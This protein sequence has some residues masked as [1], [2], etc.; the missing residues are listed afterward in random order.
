MNNNDYS[1]DYNENYLLLNNATV[2]YDEAGVLWIDGVP[3]MPQAFSI[4]TDFAYELYLEFCIGGYEDE[5]DYGK[6]ER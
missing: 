2:A 4:E 6:G 5:C 3:V 1:S